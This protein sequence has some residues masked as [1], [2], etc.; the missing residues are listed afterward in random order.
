MCLFYRA[1][2][3]LLNFHLVSSSELT[4]FVKVPFVYDYGLVEVCQT[5]SGQ[6]RA[7]NASA[8]QKD[9]DILAGTF[10]ARSFMRD[11]SYELC[12][13]PVR[14]FDQQRDIFLS[15]CGGDDPVQPV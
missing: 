10:H 5:Q 8:A 7:R 11:L 14:S 2:Q 6:Q 9:D 3:L 15:V 13:G 4:Q 1:M 12:A